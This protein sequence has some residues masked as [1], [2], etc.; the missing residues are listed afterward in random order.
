MSNDV[1]AASRERFPPVELRT[2][3]PYANLLASQQAFA[4][5]VGDYFGVCPE[6]CL[7]T[8]GTTGAIEAVRNHVFRSNVKA[9]P[10]VL[11]ARPDYWRAREAFTGFGFEVLDLHTEP[12]G[13]AIVEGTVVAK[14][15][16]ACPDVLYLSLPNNPTG[17]VF[18]AE[19]V[20]AGT[21]VATAVVMDLTLPSRSIDVRA[22]VRN[23][24]QSFRGRMN[25]YLA[26]STSKSHGTAESRIGWLIC[27]RTDDAAALRLENRNVVASGSVAAA[28]KLLK[29]GPTALE[30]IET[31][32][33]L[34]RNG[35][36]K[37][38]FELVRPEKN[39]ETGYVLIR[40]R[41]GAERVR[42]L[43]QQRN[44]RVMWGSEFGLTDDYIRLEMLA[45]RNIEIFVATV[46]DVK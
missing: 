44:I 29:S 20:I 26:G 19:T 30:A 2:G 21:P 28:V 14:A 27:A 46:N 22:L 23:L 10:T 5:A 7:A 24:Y 40:A 32:F 6:D 18:D 25:L 4:A 45:P 11:T 31:S 34:L 13:F 8:S 41:A 15:K 33:A 1:S 38:V 35:E 9:A 12:F 43:L 36:G 3:A 42:P 17:A 16:E 37:G 39:V